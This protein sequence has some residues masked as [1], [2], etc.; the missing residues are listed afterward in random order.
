MNFH[1][2]KGVCLVDLGTASEDP[3]VLS[4]I[5]GCYIAPRDVIEKLISETNLSES[6]RRIV[7]A[8]IF[9]RQ[10]CSSIA[11]PSAPEHT[12][13]VDVARG[14]IDRADLAMVHSFPYV[15]HPLVTAFVRGRSKSGSGPISVPNWWNEDYDPVSD[16]QI[17]L[18]EM[19]LYLK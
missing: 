9:M 1:D 13:W 16:L 3:L 2:D 8:V 14:I 11:D 17:K 5:L 12:K 18:A 7:D 19:G 6:D 4:V 10:L 15:F